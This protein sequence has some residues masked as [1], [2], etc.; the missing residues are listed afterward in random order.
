MPRIAARTIFAGSSSFLASS[1][2][3]DDLD[4]DGDPDL[5]VPVAGGLEVHLSTPEGLSARRRRSSRRRT[6]RRR[7]RVPATPNADSADS[8]A[9]GE[10]AKRRQRRE[11][12]V[13]TEI[14]LPRVV[15][16]SGDRRPD[17]L[18][19]DSALDGDGVR[20]RL[21]LGEG[22]FGPAFDPLPGWSV[23]A[24]PAVTAT[25]PTRRTRPRAGRWS[26]WAISTA[27]DRP[28]W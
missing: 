16:L 17:L 13:V 14:L 26:G 25:L 15:D 18:Y 27:T 22:R 3:I 2:L 6:T 19:R 20:V 1:G 28:R 24:A 8:G 21:N 5:F 7:R 11:R 23:A 4:G 9:P 10:A 12:E